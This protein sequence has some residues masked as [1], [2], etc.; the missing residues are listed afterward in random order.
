MDD[1]V[2][3]RKIRSTDWQKV[4]DFIKKELKNRRANGFR[5]RQERRWK[6][7]DRQIAMEAKAKYTPEGKEIPRSWQSAIELGELSKASEII[8][9]DVMRLIFPASRTWF[10]A[11]C[12]LP[13]QLDQESGKEME[14]DNDL[15]EKADGLVRSLMVQQHLDFGLRTR[16]ELS[17]KEALHHGSF[18]AT[19]E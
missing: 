2:K 7:V 15:Q 11:H 8:T 17:V 13:R 19:A 6:E 9:A 10:E 3:K 14:Q 12:K 4:E 1:K 5:A 16:V 18:V